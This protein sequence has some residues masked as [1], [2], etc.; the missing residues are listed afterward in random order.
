VE[1]GKGREIDKIMEFF[2]KGIPAAKGRIM[3]FGVGCGICRYLGQVTRGFSQIEGGM[4]LDLQAEAHWG[5]A[6]GVIDREWTEWGGGGRNL[7]TGG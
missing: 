3:N 4:Q 7:R 6:S 1:A 5:L 2:E